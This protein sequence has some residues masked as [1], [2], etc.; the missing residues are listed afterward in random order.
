MIGK[1]ESFH[2]SPGK[3]NKKSLKLKIGKYQ[4]IISPTSNS[5]KKS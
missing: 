5:N 1:D 4:R 2:D 3:F